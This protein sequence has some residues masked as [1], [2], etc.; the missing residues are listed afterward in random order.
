MLRIDRPAARDRRST[1]SSAVPDPLRAGVDARST[2]EKDVA[3][4]LGSAAPVG[5]DTN[6]T[7]AMSANTTVTQPRGTW[8]R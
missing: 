2:V 4:A 5:V 1:R 8:R 3:T 6:T 7:S